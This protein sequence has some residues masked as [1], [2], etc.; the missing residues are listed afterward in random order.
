ML[1]WLV[2]AYWG[3]WDTRLVMMMWL[4]PVQWLGI[5]HNHLVAGW[6]HSNSYI[7]VAVKSC[8]WGLGYVWSTMAAGG[9]RL[10]VVQW[11][12]FMVQ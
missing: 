6:V 7:P 9:L 4:F 12:C 11:I 3:S 1:W 2:T 10:G 8:H 5:V